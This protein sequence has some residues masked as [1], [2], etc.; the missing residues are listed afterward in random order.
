MKVKSFNY[1]S[2]LLNLQNSRGSNVPLSTVKS[3]I[4]KF[5]PKNETFGALSSFCVNELARIYYKNPGIEC[6]IFEEM[7]KSSLILKLENGIEKEIDLTG[8]VKTGIIYDKL[9]ESIQ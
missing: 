2:L 3:I 6:K 1:K 9:V 5:G 7:D 8:I 4:I